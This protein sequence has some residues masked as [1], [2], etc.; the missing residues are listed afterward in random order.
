[1]G[2]EAT[3]KQQA[4]RMVNELWKVTFQVN[5]PGKTHAAC[6]Q[7]RDFLLAF[8][9]SVPEEIVQT[10]DTVETKEAP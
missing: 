4:E 6:A 8:I 3:P 2:E 1:M 5:M 9:K 7:A 10:L